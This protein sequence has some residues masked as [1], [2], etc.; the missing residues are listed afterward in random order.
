MIRSVGFWLSVTASAA[1]IEAFSHGGG[2]DWRSK[3]RSSVIGLIAVQFATL[4]VIVLVFGDWPP[5][6]LLAN[7]MLAPLI[8]IAFPFA[9]A[10]SAMAFVPVIGPVAAI[11]P[12]LLCDASLAVVQRLAPVLPPV[13]LEPVAIPGVLLAAAPCLVG[14]ALLN[15]DLR[16]WWPRWRLWSVHR[17]RQVSVTLAGFVTGGLI[18][19][20][21]FRIFGR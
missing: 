17:W 19:L 20:E 3:V 1:L 16:R 10:A 14:L 9:F 5:L 4:P 13:S 7:L 12:A 6:S 18:G 15:V 21:L 8:V 11:A 2:P